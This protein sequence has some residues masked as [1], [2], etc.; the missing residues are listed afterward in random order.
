[1]T[2]A[3]RGRTAAGVPGISQ[4]G[5]SREQRRMLSTVRFLAGL[6]DTQFNVLGF[7]FGLDP[8]LGLIPFVG[9]AISASVSLYE[10]YVAKQLGVPATSL[11][12][13]L[14]NALVDFGIGL[15]PV[16]GDVGDAIFKAHARNLRIIEEHVEKI[17][18]KTVFDATA[19]R[20]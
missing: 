15:V 12:R 18:G 20:I 19:D 9:D 16:V 10:I 1:M 13:M 17:E 8:V 11:V 5:L 2:F 6:F 7:R 4:H 3:F 14:S